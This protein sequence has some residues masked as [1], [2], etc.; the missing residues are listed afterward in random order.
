MLNTAVLDQIKYS[1]KIAGLKTH[2]PSNVI[3]L[4]VDILRSLHIW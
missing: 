2:T 1:A 4:G 3:R